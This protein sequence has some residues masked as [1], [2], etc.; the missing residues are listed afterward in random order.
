MGKRFYVYLE[1]RF[2]YRC[3]KCAVHLTCKDHLISKDFMSG[4]GRAFLFNKVVNTYSGPNE[5][6]LLRTGS[7]IVCDT[8][9]N[10]CNSKIGWSY[11]WAEEPSQ[12]YKE[13][14]VIL[15]KNSIEKIEWSYS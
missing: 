1:N 4:D 5:N 15:E 12:K 9:C 13:G 6:R 11:I 7:H 8:F 3:K 10:S 2:V 14:K